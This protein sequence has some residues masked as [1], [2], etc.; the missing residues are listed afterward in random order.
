MVGIHLITNISKGL[1]VN[2]R[3]AAWE[4]RI[5]PVWIALKDRSNSIDRSTINISSTYSILKTIPINVLKIF[6]V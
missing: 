6:V 2:Y 1:A 4:K 5:V 3:L